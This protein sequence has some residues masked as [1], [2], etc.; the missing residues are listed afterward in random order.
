M[1]TAYHLICSACLS[2][3][4]SVYQN[5]ANAKLPASLEFQCYED[6]FSDVLRQTGWTLSGGHALCSKHTLDNADEIG[7]DSSDARENAP[8]S[9]RE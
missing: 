1:K 8:T 6:E 5:P 4:E 2:D 3:T 9:Q 7:Y